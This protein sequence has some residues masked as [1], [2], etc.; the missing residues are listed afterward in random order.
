MYYGNT[1]YTYLVRVYAILHLLL[2]REENTTI[3]KQVTATIDEY[4]YSR[5]NLPE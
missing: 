2:S 3:R 5:T 1:L 4:A